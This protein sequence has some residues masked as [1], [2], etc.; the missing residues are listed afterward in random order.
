MEAALNR[1]GGNGGTIPPV[2]HR[3]GPGNNANPAGRP[4]GSDLVGILRREL[5]KTTRKG[6]TAGERLVRFAMAHAAKGDFRFFE[7]ILDRMSGPMIKQAMNV[8]AGPTMVLQGECWAE[9]QKQIEAKLA[10]EQA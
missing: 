5:E 4:K 10:H 9:M 1:R 2:E 8:Y 6:D 7:A 3:F